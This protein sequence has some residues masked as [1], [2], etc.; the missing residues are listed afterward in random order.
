MRKVLFYTWCFGGLIAVY[1]AC[2]FFIYSLSPDMALG[3]GIGVIIASACFY[4]NER[5]DRTR[6]RDGPVN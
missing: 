5:I 1:F 2:K 3:V 6:H 4:L